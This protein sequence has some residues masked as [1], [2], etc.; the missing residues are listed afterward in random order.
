M[1]GREQPDL[2]CTCCTAGSECCVPGQE[3]NRCVDE[4]HGGEGSTAEQTCTGMGLCSGVDNSERQQDSPTSSLCKWQRGQLIWDWR[5]QV[6]PTR[7]LRDAPLLVSSAGV[8]GAGWQQAHRVRT[9]P[10]AAM[11]VQGAGWEG[12][13]AHPAHALDSSHSGMVLPHVASRFAP[14]PCLR[15]LAVVS[16]ASAPPCTSTANA[17]LHPPPSP[18]CLP[19]RLSNMPQPPL[20]PSLEE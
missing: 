16:R 18:P 1:W 20:S 5:R 12:A 14:L 7:A 13:A 19:P 6:P 11:V 9:A 4:K 10:P 17:F 8:S 3:G 15:A 2:Y